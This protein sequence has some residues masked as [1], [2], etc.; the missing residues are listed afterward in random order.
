MITM[1]YK[2]RARKRLTHAFLTASQSKE[3]VVANLEAIEPISTDSGMEDSTGDVGVRLSLARLGGSSEG[4][5]FCFNGFGLQLDLFHGFCRSR[6]F[7]SFRLL[8]S[9]LRGPRP[10]SR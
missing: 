6:A 3:V 4:S 9:D 8:H 10:D 5:A 7:V 2:S 1:A